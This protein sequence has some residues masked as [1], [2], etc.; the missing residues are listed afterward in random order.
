MMIGMGGDLWHVGHAQHLP[1]SRQRLQLATDLRRHP[2][3]DPDVDF[4]KHQ[5]RHRRSVAA[6]DENRQRQSGQLATGRHFRERGKGQAG[7]RAE[8]ELDALCAGRFNGGQRYQV[9][10]ER[11]VGERQIRQ[12]GGRC[13]CQATRSSGA[14]LRERRRRGSQSAV[15][16]QRGAFECG[17]ILRRGQL[18]KLR[19][20]RLPVRLQLIGAYPQLARQIEQR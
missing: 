2:A 15:C 17:D 18:L 8:G 11:G 16:G 1:R 12:F 9:D 19:L 4:I 3:T 10:G 14:L 7:V 20:D 6:D 13:I 5:R